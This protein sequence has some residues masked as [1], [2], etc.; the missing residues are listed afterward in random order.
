M[1]STQF[2]EQ[3]VCKSLNYYSVYS[4]VHI[5]AYT[6]FARADFKFQT[7]KLIYYYFLI[8]SGDVFIP[9]SRG[10]SPSAAIPCNT[11]SNVV[12]ITRTLTDCT[13]ISLDDDDFRLNVLLRIY[14][15]YIR[16]VRIPTI[17][18]DI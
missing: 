9:C 7:Y 5:K 8:F 15:K 17:G 1:L 4:A 12:L 3:L 11:R 2:L 13:R 18:V 10:F 16:N 14:K 6:L